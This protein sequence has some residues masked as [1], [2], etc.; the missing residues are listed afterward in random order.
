M[1][2]LGISCYYH[3]S[4]ACLIKDG[5]LIAAAH[6]ERFTGVKHDSSFPCNAIQ[7]CLEHANIKGKDLDFVVFYE[8]PFLKFER[9]IKT[10][11][12]TYPKSCELFSKVAL[13]W[14]KDKL[15][16]TAV[17]ADY[18]NISGGKILFSSHH[19][20]HAAS[21]FFCSPYKESAILT[22]DG[23]G[24][25][26]TTTLGVG[27]SYWEGCGQNEIKIL[28]EIRFPHSI[29]LLY[30]V[31][32]AFLGFKVNNGEYKVMGMSAFGEP[33]YVDKVYEVFKVNSDGS[34]KLD[35]K[36]FSYH[37][38]TKYSFNGNFVKLFGTPRDSE[39][40]FSLDRNAFTRENVL[41]ADKEINECRR[42]ADIAASVQKVTEDTLIKIAENLYKKTNSKRLCMAGGVA[43]NCVANYKILKQTS[44]EEIFIQ[45]AAG[46]SGGA[47]GAALYVWHCLLNKPRKFTLGH[48]YWG[49]SY[50]SGQVKDFLNKE[51]ILYREF[52]TNNA[53]IDYVV[54]ALIS[55]KITGWFQG[56][57]EW[58]PR[59]LGN[60]SILA[61]ARNPDM[62][63]KVNVRIKF[64]EQFR[65]FAP[66]VL[67][68]HAQE[69][70]NVE[71]IEGHSPFK[72]MLYAV[73]VKRKEQIPA[74]TH[75]NGTS[76]IQAVYKEDNPLYYS[77]I[78]AF[79]QRT[80]VPLLLNTS[81]N[82]KG[83]PIVDTI[84]GAYSTF[85][86]SG[87]DILVLGNF[88]IEKEESA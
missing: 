14:L 71:K 72:Y 79:Y 13:S 29:G 45:P 21:A 20:S 44:F 88:I 16:V 32:T 58:G 83:D 38:S 4:A 52:E 39:S 78:E 10:I 5:M 64:R 19:L 66:S 24:E 30:S 40:N 1:Y 69:F 48:T 53:L 33:K 81:F 65:P 60:R 11:L 62:K 74:V 67:K 26:A 22:V 15:W 12:S 37:Y 51:K 87:M 80:N 73:P 84:E 28:E 7:F 86:K 35:M 54:N 36:Y 3:D 46:D 55:Q 6:E 63:D 43:L 61:D 76:R 34:F 31:F 17:I 75:V 9:I 77:L 23:V 47:L 8:K 82:L 18:F 59:S 42:F 50:S 68:E 70:F 2:I 25:W 27:K 49:K 41:F 85:I 57:S 56:R